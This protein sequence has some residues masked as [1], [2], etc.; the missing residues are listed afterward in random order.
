MRRWKQFS[1]ENKSKK[2]EKE[3]NLMELENLNLQETEPANRKPRQGKGWLSVS[4]EELNYLSE[5]FRR[6][7]KKEDPAEELWKVILRLLKEKISESEE[8]ES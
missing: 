3:D 7:R 6:N 2:G 8:E 1:S 5:G 4:D